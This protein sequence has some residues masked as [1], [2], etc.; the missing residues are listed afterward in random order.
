[1]A[2]EV[3]CSSCQH[4]WKAGDAAKGMKMRC[5]RCGAEVVIPGKTSAPP[6]P[7]G[8][9]ARRFARGTQSPAVPT[10]PRKDAFTLNHQQFMSWLRLRGVPDMRVTEVVDLAGQLLLRTGGGLDEAAVRTAC[11]RALQE[12]HD[13]RYV[14]QL[15][16]VAAALTRFRTEIAALRR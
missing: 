3:T 7:P 11:D 12:G 8:E 6:P 10:A 15:Q 5:P 14:A 16:Q 1:M 4:G 9:A 13:R 2:V